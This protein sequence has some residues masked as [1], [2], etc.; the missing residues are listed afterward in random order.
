MGNSGQGDA[1]T[2]RNGLGRVL[3]SAM[4]FPKLSW[5]GRVVSCSEI[6]L[7]ATERLP[8]MSDRNR[9]RIMGANNAN[10]LS[11]PLVN[12]RDQVLPV[13]DL[14][15]SA[16]LDW[17]KIHWRTIV[18]TYRR[19]P[20]FEYY[21]DDL[22]RFFEDL[23]TQLIEFNIA[24]IVFLVKS[25]NLGIS[26]T[27]AVTSEAVPE[28]LTDC[29]QTAVSNIGKEFGDHFPEYHQIFSD[30]I[31]FQPNLS[32]LDLLFSEG[33]HAKAWLHEHAAQLSLFPV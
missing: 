19:T 15:I 13:E 1:M 28:K 30:R 27:A 16:D 7:D 21:E 3:V 31:G 10:L 5:W 26:V 12:G 8:K 4:P 9:Y 11:I 29:R 24:S 14:K 18:S 23:N 32:A 20:F 6:V 17:Q 22:R 33:P 2:I 25:F